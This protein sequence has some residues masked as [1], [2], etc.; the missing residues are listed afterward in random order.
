M[1]NGLLIE[2]GYDSRTASE[3]K[4][5]IT[6]PITFTTL[7]S[8]VATGYGAKRGGWHPSVVSY[9]TSGAI[10]YSGV[11]SDARFWI[12]IGS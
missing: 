1:G 7:I 4:N 11:D 10:F 9:S 2:F 6:F 8:I 5:P 12:A 3:G